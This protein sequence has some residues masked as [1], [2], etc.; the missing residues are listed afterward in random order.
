MLRTAAAYSSTRFP[1]RRAWL[2]R[3]LERCVSSFDLRPQ[4]ERLHAAQ[5]S[6]A[7]SPRA[8]GHGAGR[9]ITSHIGLAWG[10][11]VLPE[12]PQPESSCL[13]HSTCSPAFKPTEC[14][15]HLGGAPRTSSAGSEFQL[16]PSSIKR[17]HT[18]SQFDSLWQSQSRRP[19][20]ARRFGFLCCHISARV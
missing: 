2:A 3:P 13:V 16:A 15:C 18:K 20:P 8:L 11:F 4:S 10:P 12:R 7:A 9:S 1:P 5:A 17:H 19:R 14:W 6:I